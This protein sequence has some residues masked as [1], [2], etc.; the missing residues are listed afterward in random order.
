MTD[1]GTT[2]DLA[3]RYLAVCDERDALR[4]ELDSLRIENQNLQ[5]TDDHAELVQL[6]GEVER[7]R[8]ALELALDF[9]AADTEAFVAKHGLGM[10]TR[11]LC[12]RL[13]AALATQP[14]DQPQERHEQP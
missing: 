12:D 10:T 9:H 11:Q 7:L 2:D 6:R 14:H 8:M 13:R 5:G 3:Q 4:T 1:K